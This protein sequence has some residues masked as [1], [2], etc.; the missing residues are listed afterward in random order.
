MLRFPP[1]LAATKSHLDQFHRPSTW[2]FSFFSLHV[3]C[4]D[5]WWEDL[6]A[7]FEPFT[8]LISVEPTQY[9]EL[10][11][12]TGIVLEL[13]GELGCPER[14]D[15]GGEPAGNGSDQEQFI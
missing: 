10:E 15:E 6:S 3:L 12:L 9:Y 11:L 2:G 7:I 8:T 14:L 1:I 13:L 5:Y 4:K